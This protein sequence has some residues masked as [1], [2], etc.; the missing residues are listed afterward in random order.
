MG[1]HSIALSNCFIK[2]AKNIAG[3]NKMVY[4]GL[5]NTAGNKSILSNQVLKFDAKG[6]LKMHKAPALHVT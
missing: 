3:K 6:E 5:P 1:K 2:L 4:S